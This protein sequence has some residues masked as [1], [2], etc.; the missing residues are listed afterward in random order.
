[1]IPETDGLEPIVL[2]EYRE[3]RVDLEP[4]DVTY[5]EHVLN[6]RIAISR[7]FHGG[8]VLLNPAQFAGI[9]ILPS[10]RRLE[11]RPKVPVRNFFAMLAVAFDLDSDFLP[12]AT[13]YQR[14][15]EV[16]EF[17]IRYFADSSTAASAA[18]STGPTSS[19]KTTCSPCGAG[20]RSAT[21]CG[22]TTSCGTGHTAGSPN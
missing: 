1:M 17:V 5:I 13:T 21:M 11:C 22:T 19:G 10:G 8:G 6:N 16:F 9:V 18:A 4:D 3:T 15:D 12:E 14:I 20:S 7:P 2:Y